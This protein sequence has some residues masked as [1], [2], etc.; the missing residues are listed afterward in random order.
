MTAHKKFGWHR[1]DLAKK[2]VRKRGPEGGA[3]GSREGKPKEPGASCP[4][5]GENHL[6]EGP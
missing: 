6:H 3:G 2:N 4:E 5:D 1:V